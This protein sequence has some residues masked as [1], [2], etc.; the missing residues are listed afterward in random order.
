[1]EDP[2]GPLLC[3]LFNAVGILVEERGQAI[4]DL[5]DALMGEEVPGC[6]LVWR[7]C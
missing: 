5:L 7:K 1:M 2:A 3:G 6:M 4:L